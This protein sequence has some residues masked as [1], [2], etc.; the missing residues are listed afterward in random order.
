M[1]GGN[2][3]KVS[4][5]LEEARWSFA[6]LCKFK[7]QSSPKSVGAVGGVRKSG[8]NSPDS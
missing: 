6:C 7:G 8:L 2:S 5:K 4:G 1:G 3:V